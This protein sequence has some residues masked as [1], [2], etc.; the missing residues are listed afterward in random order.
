M[1]VSVAA[2]GS[3][4]V[5]AEGISDPAFG[6]WLTENERAIIEISSCSGRACGRI[7]WMDQPRHIDGSPKTDENNPDA[8]LQSR[9]IC[10]IPLVGDFKREQPGIWT[11]GYVYNPKDGQRYAAKITAV[12]PDKLEMRGFVLVPA[13]G[14]S[15]T[16]TR[17]ESTRGGC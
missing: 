16:W 2:L 1:T 8:A 10:G 17:V 3:S 7:V 6:L 15:Q 13:F 4:A 11:D 9:T 12:S 14:S 5:P